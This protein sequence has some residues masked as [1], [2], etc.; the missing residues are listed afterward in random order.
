MRWP[1]DGPNDTVRDIG[2][3]ERLHALVDGGRP[4]LVA[5]E[6]YQ[7][8]LRLHHARL[9]LAHA[10]RLANE[11]EPERSRDGPHGVFAGGVP[12]APGVDFEAGNRAQIDDMGARGAS[13]QREYRPGDPKQAEY[14]R[15]HHLNPV[16]IVPLRK[17]LQAG[18]QPGVVDQDLDCRILASTARTN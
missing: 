18:G 6:P 8:K 16:V 2:A 13:K 5:L 17:G 12:D 1:G 11:L 14:V 15:L 3:R 10:N 9:D 7:A 4:L